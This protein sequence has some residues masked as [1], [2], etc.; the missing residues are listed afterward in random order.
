MAHSFHRVRDHR[1][2]CVG[3]HPLVDEQVLLSRKCGGQD[4]NR[5]VRVPASGKPE[6]VILVDRL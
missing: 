6:I 1:V 5:C 4:L 2:G 3:V